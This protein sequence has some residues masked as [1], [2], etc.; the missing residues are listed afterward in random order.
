MNTD[1]LIKQRNLTIFYYVLFYGDYVHNNDVIPLVFSYV[2]DLFA[3]VWPL[4]KIVI[5]SKR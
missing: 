2:V 1:R 4:D 5:L 3:K